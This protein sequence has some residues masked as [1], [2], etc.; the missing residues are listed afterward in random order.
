MSTKL[1]K[2][3]ITEINNFRQD[4]LNVKHQ[5]EVFRKGISRLKAK[6]PFINEIDDF[7]SKLP[8]IPKMKPLTLNKNLCQICKIEV[9]KVIQNE[10]YDMYKSAANL[11]G[12]V[13]EA[14]LQENITLIADD[15][16]DESEKI[17]C[18]LLLNKLDKLKLGRNVIANPETTQIGIALQEYEGENFMVLL[19]AN[20]PVN[21]DVEPPLPQVDLTELKMAFDLYD[22]D[23][24]QKIRIQE[25]LEAM[26]SMKFD[27]NNPDLYQIIEE[28]KEFEYCSW[29]RFAGHVFARITDRTSEE[30]LTT[31]FNLF[32]DDPKKQTISFD[33]FKRICNE[34]GESLSEEEMKNILSNTTESGDEINLQ[35][36]IQ[37]MKL[38]E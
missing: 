34:V 35:D 24:S 38:D 15:G 8:N 4:P 36:F 2:D 14:Y 29:P 30:G 33:T 19:F 31:L 26:K 9:R 23:G 37:F 13:P 1:E 28:L 32:I 12:I 25:A 10:K 7:I 6:D 3:I 27:K 21:D 11:K 17:V 16:V 22:H 20:N 18:K 5:I